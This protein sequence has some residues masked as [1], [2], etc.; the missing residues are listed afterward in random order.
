MWSDEGIRGR[1]LAAIPLG[2]FG[3]P[4][5][6][7]AAAMLLLSRQGAYITGSSIYV[8]GGWRLGDWPFMAP[9]AG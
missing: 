1:A 2:R 7:T 4:E 3:S 9:P 8:D 5:E 6:I